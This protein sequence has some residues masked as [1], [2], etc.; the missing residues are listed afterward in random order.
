MR[1]DTIFRVGV[2]GESKTVNLL[3]GGALG[4][5]PVFIATFMKRQIKFNKRSVKVEFWIFNTET[6]KHSHLV[7]MF[8]YEK[9]LD[10]LVFCFDPSSLQSLKKC[11][12]LNQMVLSSTSGQDPVKYL[13]SIANT[14]SETKEA[15]LEDVNTAASNIKAE[16]IDFDLQE[17]M[18]DFFDSIVEDLVEQNVKYT[19]RE[20]SVDSDIR[21]LDEASAEPRKLFSVEKLINIFKRI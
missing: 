4:E 16:F 13:V 6:E 3:L 2:I 7:D 8:C 11:E 20:D 5:D 9:R 18:P 21:S 15:L 17:N 12:K 10:T 19:C 14:F 1:F